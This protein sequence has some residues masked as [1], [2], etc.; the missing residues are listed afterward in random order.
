M[1]SA[2][3]A[4]AKHCVATAIDFGAIGV[5]LLEA[6]V[7]VGAV[8]EQRRDDLHSGQSVLD[9]LGPRPVRGRHG[10]H[11]DRRIEWCSA[12]HVGDVRI[13][14]RVEQRAGGVE[15]PV[16]KRVD[17]RRDAVLVG[18]IDIRVQRCQHRDAR[19]ASLA[20]GKVERGEPAGRQPLVTRL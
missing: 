19:A 13:R 15:V 9:R 17:E 8:V 16:D 1:T 11:V 4:R 14:A 6:C 10:V 3:P 12:G 5:L 18:E 7:G 20:R 2:S